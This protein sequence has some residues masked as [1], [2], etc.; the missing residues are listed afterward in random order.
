MKAAADNLNIS[1]L[2]LEEAQEDIRQAVKE[3]FFKRETLFFIKSKVNK[4]INEAVNKIKIVNLKEDSKKSLLKF[5]EKQYFLWSTLSFNFT[6]EEIGLI[7]LLASKDFKD[8]SIMLKLNNSPTFKGNEAVHTQNMGVPLGKFYKEV[9]KE[10][11]KPTL[12]L[13]AADKAKDPNSPTQRNN[14]RNLAE[15]EVRYNDHLESIQNLRESGERLV[16][17]SS[18]A[19]CSDRC[20]E[21]QG[22]VYSLDGSYGEIDGHKYVPLEKATQIPYTTK[23]GRTYM[24]GL[25]G[26]N[27]RH[28]LYPYRG[29]I[30][31][32]IS[33]KD[34]EKEYEITKQQRAF[35][36]A[37]RKAKA[38]A[39]TNKGINDKEYKEQSAAAK[40]LYKSYIEFSKKNNRAYYPMRTEI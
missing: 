14:L 23:S 11:I 13:I 34:R 25:L 7:G 35:E 39:Q 8:Y 4:I 32:K 19:D 5:A 10:K 29:Q 27:C 2:V 21:W 15:M 30:P 38:K 40:S 6:L 22:R 3:A 26:F 36:L 24:N 37:I 31:Q 18:H 17:A 16:V 33:K 9:W 20:A 12:D 28:K 1:A